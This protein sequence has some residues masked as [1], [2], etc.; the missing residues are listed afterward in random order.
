MESALKS[1]SLITA[2][3]ALEQG[4]E[5]FALPGSIH[6]P[7][8]KG[9]HQLIRQGAKCVETV[10]HIMEELSDWP[11]MVEEEHSHCCIEVEEIEE[12]I[13]PFL[14]QIEETC[15]PVDLII[16]K[17]GLTAEK[18]SSMLLELELQDKITS[19]PG[20]YIRVTKGRK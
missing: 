20:G 15:T 4:R 12:E 10:D 13:C 6:N 3:Y 2:N 7:M 11:K 1:G 8:A 19:V 17:T 14:A 18:V 16:N 5:I 9:C